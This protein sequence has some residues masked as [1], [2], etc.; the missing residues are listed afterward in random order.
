MNELVHAALNRI[1]ADTWITNVRLANV[2][3]GEI[4]P[5]DI[6][7]HAGKVVAVEPPGTQPPRRARQRLDG[8][9]RLAVPG[10]VDAHLH[11]ESS[12]VTPAHFAAAVLPRGVTTVAEDPHEIANVLGPTG[13]RAMIQ[14]SADIPLKVLFLV[15]SSVPSAAGLETAGGAITPQDVRELLALPPVIG[16]AEV[17]DGAALLADDPTVLGILEAAGGL[18]GYRMDSPGV[19]EGH[20]P[21]LRGRALSA[22]VAAGVD[23]DHTQATPQDLVEKARLG[24]TLQLQERYLTEERIQAVM[25][26]PFDSG[27]CLVTDDVAPD[28]LLAVGHLDQV[29]RRAIALGM[30]P[31]YALRAATW[32]PA[33]RLRLWDRGAIAP[34]R[35]ADIVLVESLEDFQAQLILVD[36]QVVAQEGRCLWQ[37]PAQDP[38]ERWKETVHLP[39]QR[40]EDFA[41]AGPVQEGQV[42]VRTIDCVPGQTRVTAGEAT[43]PVRGG[44]VQLP[45]GEDLVF[46]GVVERHG[47]RLEGRGS[48]SLG[49]VRGLGLARGALATTYAHDSHNLAVMG[50][51]PEEMAR[52]ANAVIQMQG[53]IAVV[54]GAQVLARIPLPIAGILSDRPV[55]ET[56]QAL[57]RVGQALRE[58]GLEHPH[59]LMRISTFTLPVSSGLRITDLGLVDAQARQLVDLF[60]A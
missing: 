36:G 52:A 15:S 11:I 1:P 21:M 29:L 46:I 2:I 12:L 31:L 26:I 16:L 47:K 32:N 49:L 18:H 23:S 7:I 45:P 28:Y 60:L 50:R 58:L 43:V 5:A 8:Q 27:V 17:M 57:T 14:A 25:D 9:G 40:P 4:Y 37:P 20:N 35:A 39:P 19:I 51:T 10:L 24:V 3:T 6:V 55:A 33:R 38:L 22:F 34:G 53:G 54:D 56:A 13:I 42:R 41:L 30:D 59:W 48:R 44:R